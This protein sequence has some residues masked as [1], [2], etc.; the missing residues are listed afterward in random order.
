MAERKQSK[1]PR[2]QS[3]EEEAAFWGTHD[4][5]DFEDELT[6]VKNVRVA[7]PLEHHL[8]IQLD[9]KTIAELAAFARQQG[10]GLAALARTWLSERLAHEREVHSTG[11]GA[12]TPDARDSQQ[13]SPGRV[14]SNTR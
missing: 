8:T 4:L 5:A 14:P 12:G 13:R 7:R 11:V 9:A 6:V 2:F 3:Y 10:I 1:I